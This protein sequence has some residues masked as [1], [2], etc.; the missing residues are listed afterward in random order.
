MSII[1]VSF[2]SLTGATRTLDQSQDT[3]TF[4]SVEVRL[5]GLLRNVKQMVT[6]YSQCQS[7]LQDVTEYL[8]IVREMKS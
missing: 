1:I 3:D 7:L 4:N 6:R 8:D 5:E 2:D